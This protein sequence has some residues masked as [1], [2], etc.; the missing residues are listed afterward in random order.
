[1]DR[2][3]LRFELPSPHALEFVQEVHPAL[4][5]RPQLA[6]QG[7]ARAEGQMLLGAQ[8]DA[9]LTEHLPLFEQPGGRFG[10]R[11]IHGNSGPRVTH[12]RR[13]GGRALS[14]RKRPGRVD[15]P[16]PP[17]SAGGFRVLMPEL[18]TT[19]CAISGAVGS[20]V[21]SV[22]GAV[23][24]IGN[25][26]GG[27]APE[28]APPVAAETSPSLGQRYFCGPAA[29]G[30]KEDLKGNRSHLTRPREMRG[31]L[32]LQQVKSCANAQ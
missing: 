21:G 12:P 18:T 9:K 24:R 5:G 25:V 7:I 23:D 29:W 17:G 26:H 20:S 28:V 32:Y 10:W 15:F 31:G 1:M 16:A 13:D 27:V 8:E 4:R 22:G 6:G 2:G 19:Q 14:S 30:A 11:R 3:G